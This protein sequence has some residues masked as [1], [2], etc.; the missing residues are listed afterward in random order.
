MNRI[1]VVTALLFALLCCAERSVA[2]DQNAVVAA[3]Q[4]VE[5]SMVAGK[6]DEV[7]PLLK[8]GATRKRGKPGSLLEALR[9]DQK[10]HKTAPPPGWDMRLRE[11]YVVHG[12]EK[13]QFKDRMLRH[14]RAQGKNVTEQEANI[15]ADAI[16]KPYGL[17]KDRTVCLLF[18]ERSRENGPVSVKAVL[19]ALEKIDGKFLVAH[20]WDE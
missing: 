6:V 18:Y 9:R 14:F 17:T 4:F 5:K 8:E 13:E 20:V 7:V 12:D 10:I 11:I 16:A 1:I 3:L 19:V 15:S 2:S